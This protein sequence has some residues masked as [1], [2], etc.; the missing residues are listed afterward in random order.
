MWIKENIDENKL[1]GTKNLADVYMC[2]DAAYEIHINMR[3]H[4]GGA[5]S[6]GHGVLHKNKLMQKLNTKISTEAQLVQV[7]EYLP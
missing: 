7:S 2:I 1:I 3:R 4:T 6:M 5:I